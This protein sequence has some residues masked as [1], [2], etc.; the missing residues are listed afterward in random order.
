MDN[1]VKKILDSIVLENPSDE[2]MLQLALLI[3]RSNC[4][5]K[6]KPEYQINLSPALLKIDLTVHQQ[7]VI[8]TFLLNH[9]SSNIVNPSLMWI[10]GKVHAHILIEVVQIWVLEHYQ[11]LDA[12]TL[13]QSLVALQNIFVSDKPEEYIS[14]NSKLR[15]SDLLIMARILSNSSDDSVSHQADNLRR[16]LE[17]HIMNIGKNDKDN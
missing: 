12:K 3:E 10:I 2:A 6:N 5:I 16:A 7:E 14:M 4:T 15:H 1:L 11:S 9:L 8:V 13:Y 17:W